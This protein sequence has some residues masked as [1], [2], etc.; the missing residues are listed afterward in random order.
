MIQQEQLRIGI[1]VYHNHSL[2]MKLTASITQGSDIDMYNEFEPIPLT[3]DVL[4]DLEKIEKEVNTNCQE[5]TD[6][7]WQ[8]IG[9]VLL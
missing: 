9:N 7:I 6:V 4:V 1:C 5:E 2:G 3:E 8:S